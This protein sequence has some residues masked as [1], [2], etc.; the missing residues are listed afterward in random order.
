MHAT[1]DE[2]PVVLRAGD[3]S[4]RATQW[5][6]M[7][8]VVVSLPAGTDVGPLLKGN[9]DDLCPCPHWGYVV[10]GRIRI[11][12]ADHSETLSAGDLYYMPKGHT[13]VAEEDTEFIEISPPGPHDEFLRHAR[14][15]LAKTG[16]SR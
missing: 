11:D 8:A 7:K 3:A 10:S 2:L 12:Y 4:V 9:E 15:N 14:Q 6:E 16:A 1:K 13:G 5:G